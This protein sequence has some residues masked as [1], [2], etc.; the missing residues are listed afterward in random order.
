VVKPYTPKALALDQD[1]DWAPVG[2]D[3]QEE[4]VAYRVNKVIVDIDHNSL[5]FDLGYWRNIPT[6]SHQIHNQDEEE[7]SVVPDYHHY[8]Y[9][10]PA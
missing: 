8:Y 9:C 10:F 4:R 7:D 1:L 3:E 2:V 5:D 6:K